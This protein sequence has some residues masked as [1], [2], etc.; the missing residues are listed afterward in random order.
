MASKRKPSPTED[1]IERIAETLNNLDIKNDIVDQETFIEAYDN[2]FEGDTQMQNNNH[3][4]V[5]VFNELQSISSNEISD[6]VL[7][8]SR[9]KRQRADINEYDKPRIVK[10]QIV[11]TKEVKITVRG[12]V[13]TK[14]RD[15]K[16]HFASN[17]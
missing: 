8:S 17:K 1:D 15:R 9:T 16:G 3:V 6:K 4:K 10:G 13:I 5:S 12:K 7:P 2:Y 11:F 14:F